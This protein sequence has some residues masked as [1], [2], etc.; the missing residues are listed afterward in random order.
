[1]TKAD[2]FISDITILY[3]YQ[4]EN[5]YGLIIKATRQKYKTCISNPKDANNLS[6][7]QIVQIWKLKIF[8]AMKV[9]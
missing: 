2:F 5:Q 1:V 6:P 4:P 9:C 8:G 7:L 3:F